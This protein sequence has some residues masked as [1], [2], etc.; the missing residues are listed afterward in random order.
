MLPG[1]ERGLETRETDNGGQH[2]IDAVH[3]HQVNH[4]TFAGKDLDIGVRQSIA[5]PGILALV[6]DNNRI[7]IELKRLLGQQVGI[8][9]CTQHLD[10]EQVAVA[11]D[12][13]EGLC[14]YRPRRT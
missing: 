12:H 9:A 1:T 14:P 10:G 6:G 2:H 7:G 5:Q 3:L 8:G 11:S 4:R 13:I